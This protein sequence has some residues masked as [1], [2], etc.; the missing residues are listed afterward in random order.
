[1]IH[2]SNKCKLGNHRP[3]LDQFKLTHIRTCR[4]ARELTFYNFADDAILQ[5]CL[6]CLMVTCGICFDSTKEIGELDSCEHR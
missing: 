4:F 2:P 5:H 1:M 6:N 3:V